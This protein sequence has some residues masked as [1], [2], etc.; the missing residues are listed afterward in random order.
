M[1]TYW[2]AAIET[3]S[4]GEVERLQRDG[5]RRTLRACLRVPHYRDRLARAGVDPAAVRCADDLASVPFMDKDQLRAMQPWGVC[6]T[7]L[8]DVAR[9][10]ATTGTT[11]LPCNIAFTRLD[12]DD[13]GELGARNLTAMGVNGDDIAWQCYGY[14]LWIGGSALD[15]AYERVGV[16]AFP[17][18]PG[19]TSLAIERL[20][21]LGVTV[22]SCTPTF[23]LLLVERAREAGID[24]ATDWN[25]RVGIFGGET[26]SP[27]AVD[28]LTE[29]MPAGFQAHNTYG[30][31]ELGGPFVAGTCEFSAAQGTVHVWADH[32]LVEIVDPESGAR[33]TQPGV[34]GELVVTSL[35]REASPMLRW[36]TRDLTSWAADAYDCPCGRR[37]H[38]KISWVSGR[39]DDVLKVRGTLVMPSQVD[40]VVRATVGTGAGWQLVVDKDPEGLRATE[41]TVVVEVAGGLDESVV[42]DIGRRLADRLGIRL[43][44]LASRERELPRYEGKA[45]RVLSVTEFAEVAP[46]L[47]ALVGARPGTVAEPAR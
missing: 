22:I 33:V 42:A 28:L 3:A 21:D 45:R 14:G 10:N 34:T 27:A 12:L 41:A 40:D 35:R 2:S 20:R 5:L 32:H 1:T 23:A 9:F 37:A 7:P 26:M 38:P 44:V 30:T 36:R 13:I 16:T 24:P 31:T 18:G 15:R 43:P 19:R 17:A 39:T 4:V 29:A 6:A 47:A 46:S 11:G 25:L 8:A